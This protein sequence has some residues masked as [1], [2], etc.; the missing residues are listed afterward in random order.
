MLCGVN[1]VN[2]WLNALKPLKTIVSPFTDQTWYLWDML[3][4]CNKTRYSYFTVVPKH[5]LW[6]KLNF[7][8]HPFHPIDFLFV[9]TW[10]CS[11]SSTVSLGA[12]KNYIEERVSTSENMTCIWMWVAFFKVA[13]FDDYFFSNCDLMWLICITPIA[14]LKPSVWLFTL[15]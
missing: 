13:N 15:F 7:P 2:S 1:V 9:V 14:S 4:K 10:V 6:L 5:R 12:P 3:R 11:F 8:P